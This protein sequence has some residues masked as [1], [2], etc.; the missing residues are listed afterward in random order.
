MPLH[1][2]FL[3]L[4]TPTAPLAR[5][6]LR[7]S[8]PSCSLPSTSVRPPRIRPILRP[9]PP[10]PAFV[11]LLLLLAR[12]AYVQA[13]NLLGSSKA[14]TKHMSLVVKWGRERSASALLLTL[15]PLT[16]PLICP[17]PRGHHNFSTTASLPCS[18]SNHDLPHPACAGYTSLSPHPIQSWVSSENKSPTTLS[19]RPAH[20]NSSMP[21][22]S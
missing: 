2:S 8:C 14:D 11:P 18:P 4:T 10:C 7:H 12:V 19:S 13:K 21:A 1:S 16:Y 22:P 6:P 5:A 20:S 9:S 15:R 3:P 17:Q